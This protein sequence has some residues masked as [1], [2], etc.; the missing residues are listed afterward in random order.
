MGVP[1]LWSLL[2]FAQSTTTL[3]ALSL[4]K[5]NTQRRGYRVGIDASIW[6][7]HAEYGKEGENPELRTLFFRCA[8]LI[9]HGF[10]PLFVFDGPKRPEFKRGKRIN[11]SAHK[12]VTGMQAI[13]EAFGFEY[14]TA[15]GEAEAE[16]AWLNRIGI[17]DG[18]LSD[19]V[20]TFLFGAR[21]VIRNHSSTHPSSGGS[22]SLEKCMVVVYNLPHPDHAGFD[23]EDLI[24]IALCSGGDYDGTGIPS[25]GIK[26][27]HGLALA[28]FG[29]SLHKHALRYA[30]SDEPESRKRREFEEFLSDWRGN[31][32]HELK[33]NASGFLPSKKPSLASKIPSTF[34]NIEVL[35]SY[36]CPETSESRG[37]IE[38]YNDLN[39]DKGWLK[40]DPSLPMLAEKCEFYFE[41]GF[42]ESIIKRFRTVIFHGLVLRILRRVVLLRDS[43]DLEDELDGIADALIQRHFSSS[44]YQLASRVDDTHLSLVKKICST[45]QHV[46]TSQTL[47]YRLEIHPGFLVRLISSGIKGIRRPDDANEWDSDESSDDAD[48][49]NEK[50]KS[51]NGKKTYNNP[52]EPLRVWVPAVLLKEALPKLTEDFEEALRRKQE[53]KAGKGRKTKD[54]SPSKSR[55]KTAPK[56]KVKENLPVDDVVPEVPRRK[57]D[58]PKNSF[59]VALDSDILGTEY[60]VNTLQRVPAASSNKGKGKAKLWVSSDEDESISHA[61]KPPINKSQSKRPIVNIQGRAITSFFNASKPNTY[62]Q[63]KSKGGTK[64]SSVAGAS[65][66]ASS[67]PESPSKILSA[68]D[69]MSSKRDKAGGDSSEDE[70]YERLKPK[71]FPMLEFVQDD[72]PFLSGERPKPKPFPMLEFVQ[73]DDSF[74]SGDDDTPPAPPPQTPSPRKR[75]RAKNAHHELSSDDLS[76][77]SPR[78]L[79]K[80]NFLLRK[81]PRKD[82]SHSSP[83]K[84]SARDAADDAPKD[85]RAA[86]HPSRVQSR[87]AISSTLTSRIPN[88]ATVSMTGETRSLSRRSP[89]PIDISDIASDSDEGKSVLVIP[90]FKPTVV[91]SK[92][93]PK[94]RNV[95]VLPEKVSS[96]ATNNSSSDRLAAGRRDR[97]P[98]DV[99]RAKSKSKT[100]V[101]QTQ[102]VIIDIIDLT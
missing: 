21:T 102:P 31:L 43:S 65:G 8:Q 3:T 58:K 77:L 11:K 90:K 30:R 81:S 29:K 63:G 84:L 48:S 59:L 20:D 12:L 83:N 26:F 100:D 64:A 79:E 7:F 92:P 23:P 2:Q 24:F 47:E 5:F 66:C 40:K 16:L 96:S 52:S 14:R 82:T 99:A 69:S 37:R 62:A 101:L 60:D 10:L 25:C 68:L 28:G 36:I 22:N 85:K 54:A 15:P 39:E 56:T 19:D 75:A 53:K 70:P 93:I 86:Q 38:R 18:I 27:A 61:P 45:R 17:I 9:N 94:G 46:S 71:P 72:D 57:S 42:E 51:K 32:A 91:T 87:G 95:K 34:P 97:R 41:W 74:L 55:P 89:S 78:S 98:L 88:K 80:R 1:G 67:R 6:F 44:N 35:M 49:G 50:G 33:T 76:D 73:D 13:I 4:T